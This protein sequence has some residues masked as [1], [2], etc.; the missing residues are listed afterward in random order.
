MRMDH[1]RPLTIVSNPKTCTAYA[2]GGEQVPP[3]LVS[4]LA[5]TLCDA[6]AL[7]MVD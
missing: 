2:E 4:A 6:P 5:T 7:T 3:S 1:V